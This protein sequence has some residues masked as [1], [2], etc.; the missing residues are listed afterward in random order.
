MANSLNVIWL[1][2]TGS[3]EDPGC[4]MEVCTAVRQ[5]V[6]VLPVR[7][8]GKGIR[9]LDL[10]IWGSTI[11]PKNVP[12]SSPSPEKT[13]PDDEF[14]S[15]HLH[16]ERPSSGRK[17]GSVSNRANEKRKPLVS[18][19][20]KLDKF[21]VQLTRDLPK[22]TQEELH[23]NHFLVRDV[24]AAVRSC[25]KAAEFRTDGEIVLADM[26]NNTVTRE[27][28]SARNI[29]LLD[30]KLASEETIVDPAA[31][32][33]RSDSK[34]KP[35]TA[36]KPMA[37]DG[38]L[39]PSPRTFSPS[40]ASGHQALFESLIGITW[41]TNRDGK[42][43]VRRRHGAAWNW[44]RLPQVA[45]QTGHMR[46]TETVPWRSDDEVSELIKQEQAEIDE[47]AGE[48]EMGDKS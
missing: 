6:P 23:R 44:E 8:S 48:R 20:C 18:R 32:G 34:A 45:K 39:Y 31:A 28:D 1:L 17:S 21:Y 37:V 42:P 36:A 43:E 14:V 46:G 27:T 3:L 7:L 15:A 29:Q 2:S 35:K 47:L 11:Q 12:S 30:A 9:K 16:Q 5:G 24:I 25:F 26:E 40:A 4:L 38:W 33:E 10:P 19:C 41:D 13:T 22:A